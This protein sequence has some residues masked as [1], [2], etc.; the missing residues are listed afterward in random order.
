M[1]I[2][3]QLRHKRGVCVFCVFC[4]F[5]RLAWNG[6]AGVVFAVVLTGFTVTG[7]NTGCPGKFT[8]VEGRFLYTS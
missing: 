8:I 2:G 5:V 1:A 7:K 6:F 4:V 3:F